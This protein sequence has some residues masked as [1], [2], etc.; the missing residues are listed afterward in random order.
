M[1][2]TPLT[3]WRKITRNPDEGEP[4]VGG[5]EEVGR[6]RD[7]GASGHRA[8]GSGGTWQTMGVTQMDNREEG[9]WWSPDSASVG[10][11][12]VLPP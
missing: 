7:C 6:C 1:E 5:P 11:S 9:C 3:R 12:P 4:G 2:V 10:G 8:W